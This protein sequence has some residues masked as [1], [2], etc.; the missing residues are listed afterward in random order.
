MSLAVQW[1]QSAEQ[2]QRWIDDCRTQADLGARVA[3]CRYA[4]AVLLLPA[5]QADDQQIRQRAQQIGLPCLRRTGGGAAVLAGPW[6]VSVHL[7]VNLQVAPSA[8]LASLR[9]Q[10][11]A[12]HSQVLAA[13]GACAMPIA[14][15]VQTA[16]QNNTWRKSVCFGKANTDE[17]IDAQ[18]RKVVGISQHRARWGT[19]IGSGILVGECDWQLLSSALAL[20]DDASSQLR[21]TTAACGAPAQNLLR[22][23]SQQLTEEFSAHQVAG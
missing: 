3:V 7:W 4:E 20:P 12:T 23:I 21:M 9:R 2:E 16:A 14:A 6:M 15:K 19:W 11:S 8:S 5:G 18:G 13:H 17:L 22:D 1:L 10:F